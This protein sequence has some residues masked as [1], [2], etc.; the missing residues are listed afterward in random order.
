MRHSNVSVIAVLVAM[1]SSSALA[2]SAKMEPVK[3]D[4][5][6]MSQCPFGVTA[7]NVIFPVVRSLEPHV[8]FNLYF[9]ADMEPAAQAAAPAFKSLHGQPEVDENIRHLCAMKRF[10][11]QYMDFILERNVSNAKGPDWQ[12]AARKVGIDPAALDACASG[13]EG[14]KLLSDSI[15]VTQARGAQGSPT[16][17]LNG[18]PYKG[19]RSVRSITL[20]VCDALNAKGVA[21]PDACEKAK[22]MP[23]DAPQ[24]G[25]APQRPPVAFDVKIVTDPSCSVC[26][27]TLTESIKQSHAGARIS[28]LDVNSEEGRDLVKRYNI[29][30]LPF[31]FLE[32]KI[33]SDPNFGHMKAYYGKVRDDGYAIPPRP[34]TFA[35]SVQLDRERIPRHLD[36]FVESLSPFTSQV[37]SQLMKFLAESDIQDLTFSIHY[38]MHETAKGG[39]EVPLAGKSS[40]DAVRSAPLK[41]ELDSVSTG[42][43]TSRRGEPEVQENMRQVCLFQHAPVGTFFTYLTCRNQNILDEARGDVCLKMSEPIQQCLQG[44][45][46]ESLL[47][48]DA[49]L[50]RELGITSGP[51]LLWENRYGPFGWYEVDWKQMMMENEK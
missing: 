24:E 45:E 12:A 26:G 31:Y 14:A 38:I 2:G 47:R 40:P 37:E 3:F 28:V 13:E 4:L 19:S 30:T 43:L 42:P 32:K 27:P 39:S 25:G 8:D 15:K 10:P 44:P 7:E 5:Y 51:V 17:D 22:A 20:A 9:I 33:E 36:I 46:A 16:I 18:A 11:K 48:R 41:A 50:V 29:Q 1:L 35:P 21:L 34:D 23:P 6:V 49:R